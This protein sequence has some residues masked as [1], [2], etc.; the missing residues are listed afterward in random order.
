MLLAPSAQWVSPLCKSVENTV[1]NSPQMRMTKTKA[2]LCL[3]VTSLLLGHPEDPP[4]R[5]GS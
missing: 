1:L 3:P 2:A 5:V 4:G